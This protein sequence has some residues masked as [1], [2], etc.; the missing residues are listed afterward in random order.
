MS[1]RNLRSL[2][3][4]KSIKLKS[5]KKIYLKITVNLVTSGFAIMVE[6]PLKLLHVEI[7]D[8]YNKFWYM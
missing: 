8:V 6:K 3:I 5:L 7:T 4:D 2:V 1:Q